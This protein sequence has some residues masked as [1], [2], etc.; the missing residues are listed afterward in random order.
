MSPVVLNEP[1]ALTPLKA[2][3]RL[4]ILGSLVLAIFDLVPSSRAVYRTH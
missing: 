1:R 3:V 4:L 2:Q